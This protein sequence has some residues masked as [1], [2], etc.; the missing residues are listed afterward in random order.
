ME[1]AR[2]AVIA[3]LFVGVSI[4]GAVAAAVGPAG[5][6]PGPLAAVAWP[7]ST[8]LVSELQ[9]GGTSASD[10][11]AEI[12]NVGA[13]AV[14]LAGL[15]VVYVTSTGG[16]VTRKASWPS[17]QLLQ[18]GRHLLIANTSGIF[19]SLADLTYS[20]GFAATGGAVAIRTIG[21]SAIDALG[22][23]DATNAF[24]EGTAAPAPAAGSSLERKHGGLSGN[25]VDTND[26]LG[27]WFVQANPDPQS[28]SAPP[29][30]A[31]VPTA[32]PTASA[33]PAPTPAPTASPDATPGPTVGPTATPAASAAPSPTPDA[34]AEPTLT[35]APTQAPTA[36]PTIAVTPSPEPTAAP[37]PESTLVPTPSP[38]PSPTPVA[39]I[40]IA[41]ARSL[42]DG[43]TA[44]IAGVLTTRLAALEGGRTAF[45]QDATGGIALYLD[46]VPTDDLA[47]GTRI[48]VT[49]TVD[50][51]YAQRTL[52]VV[53][54]DIV[55]L[56]TTLVPD[57]LPVPAGAID[58]SL[59]GLR[60]QVM[61]VTVGSPT[62]Y[63]D[64]LGILVDDGTGSIRVIVGPDALAGANV[65]SGTLVTAT[66]PAGQHDSTGTGL[67]G[68]RI[69]AT[70][71]GELIVLPTPTPT[72]TP[73][74]T[75]SPSNTPAPTTTPTATPSP[76]P[77]QTPAPS[78][79]PSPT[80]G[81]ISIRSAR[82]LPVGKVVTVAGVVTAEAGRLGT[83]SVIAIQDSTGGI[84]VRLPDGFAAPVRGTGVVVTGPI[85]D[86]YG[87]LE[88]RPATG[89]IVLTGPG[90]LPSP[91]DIVATDLGEGTE[92]LLV[93][94]VG[95]ASK[96]ASK[97]TS[98]DLSIDLLD[99]S[100]HAFRVLVDGSSGITSGDLPTGRQLRITGIAGQR[101][102]RKGALDGY[103]I[104]AR[105]RHDV[106]PITA[107]APAPTGAPAISIRSALAK[108][109]GTPVII[110]ATVT[111]GTSLLD[112]S[113]RRIVVE[114]GSAAI[115]VLLPAGTAGPAVGSVLRIA[116][117]TAHA[118]GAPRLRATTVTDRHA[119]VPIAA[120]NRTTPVA[121]AD[122]WRLVRIS[123]TV[124]KV[125]RFGDRWRIDLELAGAA[126]AHVPVLGQSGAGIPSTRLVEGA[127]VT[128]TGIVKRPYP[129]ASD[130]RF[131]VLPRGG[132][133]LVTSAGSSGSSG[134]SGS[135]TGGGAI[136]G[137]ADSSATP[138]PADI[139]PDTDLAV[140]EERVGQQVRIG[141][142]VAA[143]TDDGL[144][145][146]DGTATAHLVLRGDALQLL[147][148]MRVGDAIAASGRV[149]RLDRAVVVIVAGAADLVRVGDLGQALPVE[150]GSA[151][152]SAAPSAATGLG[153]AAAGPLVGGP[154]SMSIL[155]MLGLSLVSLAVT[156]VRR[157]QA[158][159]RLRAVI[160]A[161]L[162]TLKPIGSRA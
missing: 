133:D 92:G 24:V 80:M 135:G 40:A 57:P 52:R 50:D 12:T 67:G 91:T 35:P 115:E 84:T 156:I 87:Q 48:Q 76:S 7:P 126:H 41:D 77:T 154:E 143:L 21:G 94:L 62:A 54:A 134:S 23:G 45:V 117:V 144:D 66:G 161:R 79:T 110:E 88:L 93:D 125:E 122:E 130:R 34:T 1:R 95:V 4:S 83:P 98:G 6:T 104:W 42:P 43:S 74:P 90:S 142:L 61:G 68:Y 138:L 114:D 81:P 118:W 36:E 131:A 145:L 13:T 22:W 20:G 100:G 64:G 29:V 58:E 129:T 17:T 109:D 72:S 124:V 116:G 132:A 101:A 3:A 60:I 11:F 85:N 103:R 28:L 69:Q 99:L 148:H 38:S 53:L 75:P 149:E 8:L 89:G 119:A 136:G 46:A 10:E 44:T 30:P 33:S 127:T 158:Q 140:L 157:R 147:P 86:P 78:P 128:I 105:D 112:T 37:T 71:P 39:P 73:T 102:S 152:P 51:R 25:T 27:D 63:A 150:T 26:N 70:E 19:A 56:D 160:V 111:A 159:R 137:S 108:P 123:G 32:T 18:P 16:T 151:P 113:A 14:D 15:E 2:V 155:A 97:G 65:P 47:A 31:P 121:A 120:A 5:L 9:T 162:A 59:E 107:P 49:G 141:G 146:D 82:Q 153:I 106:V 55:V 96:P 139:S